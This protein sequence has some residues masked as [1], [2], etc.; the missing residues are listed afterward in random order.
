MKQ[1]LLFLLVAVL[2]SASAW[3]EVGD[4]FT[5]DGLKYKVTGEAP[6]TVEN[7]IKRVVLSDNKC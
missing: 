3:A 4:E 6:K 1:K 5:A 7:S 2:M